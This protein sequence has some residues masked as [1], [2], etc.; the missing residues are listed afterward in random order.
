M[1]NDVVELEEDSQTLLFALQPPQIPQNK[2][3]QPTKWFYSL[4]ALVVYF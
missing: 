4:Y 3:P 2:A 1:E